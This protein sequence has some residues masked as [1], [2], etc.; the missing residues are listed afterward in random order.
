MSAFIIINL[1][2]FEKV[3]T[4]T[5][6]CRICLSASV[7]TSVTWGWCAK[8][9]RKSFWNSQMFNRYV[10]Q[11]PYAETSTDSS[12]TCWSCSGQVDKVLSR[13]TD[14][15]QLV[16]VHRRLRG[17]WLSFSRD[18]R[19]STLPQGEIPR[20]NYPPPRQPRVQVFVFNYSGKLPKCMGSS[21]RST[22]NTGTLTPGST[23]RKCSTTCHWAP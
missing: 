20:Q 7:S 21:T 5:S 1:R 4:L 14:P 12:S 19:V 23:A 11:W 9:P 3:W 15:I 13:R 17:P 18:L 8:R 16:C 22:G 6:T 2:R 10:R